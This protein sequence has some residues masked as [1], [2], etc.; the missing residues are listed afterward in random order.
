MRVL[1]GVIL[2]CAACSSV[3]SD[4]EVTGPPSTISVEITVTT[5][6]TTTTP[7]APCPPA[8]Y[9]LGS[10]PVRVDAAEIDLA[11]ADPD[12]DEFTSIGGTNIRLWVGGD[13]LPAI[14]LVR[15][16]L[17]PTDFPAERGEVDVAGTRGVAGPYPDGRWVVAWYNEPGDRCDLYSMVFYPPVAPAEVEQTIADMERR[18]G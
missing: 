3:S 5:V 4:P 11:D 15:G 2:V 10:L 14:A 6:T 8:P 1:L 12:P 13:G 16:S 7:P 17:P 9:D 18:A